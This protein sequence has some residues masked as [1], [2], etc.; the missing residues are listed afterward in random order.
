MVEHQSSVFL[1]ILLVII[2]VLQI[3][4]LVFLIS[5]YVKERKAPDSVALAILKK[6]RR[7]TIILQAI[8]I[9]LSFVAYNMG[10][11]I[12]PDG[13]LPLIMHVTALSLKINDIKNGNR[14]QKKPK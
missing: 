13:L 4:W 12:R 2:F 9:A 7:R 11:F 10:A 8:I 3:I 14:H 6:E 1:N 5:T